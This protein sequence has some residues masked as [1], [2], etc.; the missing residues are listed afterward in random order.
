[1][2]QRLLKEGA[3]INEVDCT[4]RSA[5]LVA[6]QHDE[7]PLVQCLVKEGGAGI[8]AMIPRRLITNGY[9]EG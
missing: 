9:F 2:S 5:M 8:D 6:V 1:M 3:S 4:G 7:I